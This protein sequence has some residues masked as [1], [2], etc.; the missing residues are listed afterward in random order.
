M[1]FD[2]PG[3]AEHATMWT[4]E[5][6]GGTYRVLV[7]KGLPG[8]RWREILA[9]ADCAVVSCEREAALSPAEIRAAIGD[10]CDGVIGQLTERWDDPLF[11][12]LG[13]AGGRVYSNYAVG[14]DNV[15][16]AAATAR[17]I[18]VGNTPGVLTETTAELAAALTFAAA[19]RV[20]ESDRFV[21]DGR[22]DGWLPGMFLGKRLY[23][24]TLGVVGAGR[25]GSAYAR[26][27]GVG[28]GMDV[29]YHARSRKPA[30]ESYFAAVAPA[31]LA[32]SGRAP[33]C[34][35]C[36]DL[37]DLLGRADVVALHVPLSESTRQLIGRE[38]LRRM[39]SDAVLVNTSRGAVIDEAALV[40]HLRENSE[41]RAG[42]D[43][44]EREPELAPGLSDLPNAVIVP[45]IGS[46]TVWTRAGMAS[47]A[48]ANVAGVLRGDPLAE[49]LDI[50]AV[51]AGPC[52]RFIP[53]L[54]NADPLGF[55]S[56]PE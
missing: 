44:F 40:E 54:V 11:A 47:L 10:R 13:A 46:A 43:V 15:D 31:A 33:G 42:L 9:D 19:R 5:N 6:D 35:F 36:P 38:Q 17:R 56:S 28:C 20:V 34:E 3:G 4:T 2:D 12:A 23:G 27:L 16:V 25:I 29:L 32:A 26:L 50:D 51:L 41:F 14:Y 45:H 55:A 21:R 39:K 37:D 1:S 30:L 53:S 52:P 7:T 49:I 22:W 24:Q 48:A 8:E 18:A